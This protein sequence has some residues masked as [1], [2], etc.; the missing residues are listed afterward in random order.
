M[1]KSKIWTQSRMVSITVT[2]YIVTGYIC[3]YI[4]NNRNSLH[5]L[6]IGPLLFTIP[7][8]VVLFIYYKKIVGDIFFAILCI[9]VLLIFM[10]MILYTLST[11]TWYDYFFKL[12]KEFIHLFGL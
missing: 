12:D 8:F 6:F 1:N 9:V 4:V 11:Q 2:L 7:L 3:S 5:A 10:G